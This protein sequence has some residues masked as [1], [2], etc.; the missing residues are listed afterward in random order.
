MRLKPD[1]NSFAAEPV[2]AAHP[3][4]EWSSDHPVR[5]ALIA[6]A[7]LVFI[8]FAGV[9]ASVLAVG[10]YLSSP[11]RATI[12]TPPGVLAD[13]RPVEIGTAAGGTLRGWWLQAP[14]K[15]GGAVIL[16]HGV[17][18]NRLYMVRR[19]QV[20]RANGFSV[21]LFDLQAHGESDGRRITFG[22]L[23]AR[24][25]AD[26]VDFVHRTLPDERIGVIG[27]SLGGAAAVL[28]DRPLQIDALVLE[29]VYP[30]INA[31]LT[32]RLRTGLGLVFRPVL[33]PLLSPVFQ[34]LLPPVL[35]ATPD[36]LRPIDRIATIAAP[37]LLAAGTDDDRTTL[38]ESR[39]LFDRAPRPKQFWPV[40]GAAHVDL[41]RYDTNE[42]WRVVLPF[43]TEHLKA[44]AQRSR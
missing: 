2:T 18:N 4:A 5:R 11:A 15:G 28:G 16:M 12:G 1:A 20:L 8:S 41:E 7:I 44:D 3:V 42:Y 14:I 32:N 17:W 22:R 13:A 23:E 26:A 25:A 35:G 21:L 27:V 9:V 43:L 30:D 38:A 40:S 19:A 24:G 31:A 6:L 33:A 10:L 29:S 37:L 34:W 39:A 36:E